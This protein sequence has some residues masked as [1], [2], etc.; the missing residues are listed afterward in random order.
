MPDARTHYPF[1][2]RLPAADRAELQRASELTGIAP[3]T[4]ARLAIAAHACELV[5]QHEQVITS[6]FTQPTASAG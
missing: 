4:I 5:A 2:V 1:S 6:P 3:S